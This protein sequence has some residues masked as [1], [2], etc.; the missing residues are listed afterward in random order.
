MTFEII[1]QNYA[2]NAFFLINIIALSQAQRLVA[3]LQDLYILIWTR[4]S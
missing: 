4:I 2:I 3:W 1:Y